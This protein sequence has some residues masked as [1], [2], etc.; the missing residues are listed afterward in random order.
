MKKF[1]KNFNILGI[2]M[3]CLC[4][5][6]GVGDV[7]GALMADGVA[8]KVDSGDGG[9]TIHHG[10]RGA[11]ET[12]DLRK[13]TPEM[14][15]DPVDQ[16]LVKIRPYDTPLDTILRYAGSM[17]SNSFEFGWYSIGTRE[18][19]DKVDSFSVTP[20]SDPTSVRGT[21][22]VKGN[23][24]LFDETDTIYVPTIAGQD[25]TPLMLYVYQKDLQNS[26]L[27]VTVSEDQMTS[28]TTT[29]TTTYTIPAIATDTEIFA[30]GRA[31]AEKDVV[32]PAMSF[33]PKKSIGYCQ[34]FKCQIAQTAYEKLIDKEIKFDISEV[35][36]QA[37][38]EF[39]RRMEGTFLFGH[40]KKIYDPLKKTYVYTTC[41]ITNQIKKMS[42]I[43]SSASD[44]NAEMVELT[45]KVFTGNSGAKER[46]AIA[47]SEAIAKISK[48]QGVEKRQDAVKTEVIWG[49]TWN[50]IVT[51]F[52]TI[53]L[54][55]HAL[56]DEY[57]YSSKMIV[58]DPQFIKKWQLTNFERQQVDAKA[59][60]IMNGDI[61]IFTEASGVAVYNPD[62]HCIV[63]VS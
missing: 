5:V 17:K 16:N 54:V 63:T 40:G 14:I 33:L 62:A 34:I 29:T 53:N 9:T 3:L 49:I 39:R 13:Y 1:L 43:N 7:S 12:S 15:E 20:H 47:G 23:V 24:D 11:L 52:G 42:T 19:S 41:G 48:L 60:T 31:A 18:L 27:L 22:K 2:L 50:K 25:G 59:L 32:T 8:A 30:L 28:T 35:E 37:L 57:G 6:L 45:K 55:H 51:N 44:G 58:I 56:L 61:T 26:S 46:F 36:E 10:F 38:Y 4:V 21:L